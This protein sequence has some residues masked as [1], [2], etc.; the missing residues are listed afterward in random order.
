MQMSL[1]IF[2]RRLVLVLLITPVFFGH[3]QQYDP[4]KVDKKAGEI[5]G[6]GY[7]A[8]TNNDY[9][10]AIKLFT[11]S[12]KIDPKLVDA[13]LSRSGVYAN[14]KN[15]TAAVDDFEKALAIDPVYSKVFYLPYSISLAGMGK[16]QRALDVVNDFLSTPGLNAKSIAAGNS[17]KRTYEFAVEYEKKH[18]LNGYMFSPKN[19]GDS[20]NSKDLEYF[21]SFTIDGKKMIYNKRINNDEDFYESDFINGSWSKA[22]PIGGKVN[23]NLNEGAQNISQDGQLLMFTGC[24][25]PEGEGS[26]D[27]YFSV[28]T[29]TGWSEAQ[30]LGPVVNTDWWESSPSLSPDKRDLYF[31]SSRAGGFGGRDIWVTHRLP[32]GKWSRPENLGEAVNTS[33]DESC[34]FMHADNQSLYF[35]SNGHKGYG[36][37]DLFIS[38]KVNDSSW[39]VAENLGYPI[40]TIDDEGSLVVTADGQ[41]A[42]YASERSDSRGGLD[43]Y[44]FTL[45]KDIQPSRTLWVKG[46]VF[47]KKT[48][49]GLPSLVELTDINTRNVI[50][51]LQT[52]EDGQYLVTLPEGKS[53]AFNVNR[54]G[55]L[56]YS[57]N[58]YLNNPGTDSPLVKDIPLQ[59]IEAGALIVLKNIFFD[60]KS[61][62]LKPSSLT[63]LDKLVLLMNENPKLNIRINGHTDNVGQPKDNLLLS[64]NRAK[65]VVQYLSSKGIPAQRL[66]AKGFGATVPLADNNTESGRALNRRTEVSVIS[67]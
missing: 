28:R 26:C 24:N 40:N 21:P 37:T 49:Q 8:A 48:G 23:T 30:N 14:L 39:T 50:S 16:F 32:N 62:E 66:S 54:K 67:N 44:S 3:A 15:Y 33:A 61:F 52:D 43:L 2:L 25:Y 41:T 58:F 27:L 35:N 65:A 9:A 34:P 59:P 13:Y 36:M 11:E 42:Y 7:E 17:R 12:L 46:K 60:N 55:Y 20:I 63:E 45:R 51:R 18:P 53:Y 5:Y 19:M 29:N 4:E 31:A 56:F 38:K 57:D 47:D 1:H 6:R 22:K 10:N 64:D